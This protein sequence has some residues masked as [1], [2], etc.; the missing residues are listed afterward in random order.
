MMKVAT[1]ISTKGQIIHDI[2]MTGKELIQFFSCEMPLSFTQAVG[3]ILTEGS[4]LE[5]LVVFN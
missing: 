3:Y 5:W 2:G 1:S 4:G